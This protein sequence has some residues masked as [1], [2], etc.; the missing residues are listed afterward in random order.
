MA[1]SPIKKTSWGEFLFGSTPQGYDFG[2]AGTIDV[3][4]QDGNWSSGTAVV[5]DKSLLGD[6]QYGRWDK[7]GRESVEQRLNEMS[8]INAD[9]YDAMYGAYEQLYNLGGTSGAG[10]SDY[11]NP[12]M[13]QSYSGGHGDYVNDQLNAVQANRQKYDS[14]MGQFNASYT[15]GHEVYAQQNQQH[16]A[17]LADFENRRMASE[18]AT[19]RN[20]AWASNLPMQNRQNENVP[21]TVTAGTSGGGGDRDGEG[22]VGGGPGRRRRGALSS[23]LGVTV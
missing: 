17:Q 16:Q 2:D 1:Y 7:G 8:G 20:Q 21:E 23:N 4:S 12:A 11:V 15:Q 6:S 10:F 13:G 14:L 5:A 22:D 9:A 3:R 18:A 19:R